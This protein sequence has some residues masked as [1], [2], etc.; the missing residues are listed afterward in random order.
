MVPV[1]TRG[2]RGCGGPG[3]PPRRDGRGAAW[4]S[5]ARRK[6]PSAARRARCRRSGSSGVEQAGELGRAERGDWRERA[7]GELELGA[8]EA[9]VEQDVMGDHHG[10]LQQPG[11]V[12]GD[13]GEGWCGG[14]HAVGDAVDLGG[15]DRPDR[16]QEGLVLLDHRPVG[17]QADDADLKGPVQ[18]PRLGASGLQVDHRPRGD[19]E[20]DPGRSGPALARRRLPVRQALGRRRARLAHPTGHTVAPLRTPGRHEIRSIRSDR[21]NQTPARPPCGRPRGHGLPTAR[22]CGPAVPGPPGMSHAGGTGRPS[23]FRRSRSRSLG[24]RT[25][26]GPGAPRVQGGPGGPALALPREVSA[27]RPAPPC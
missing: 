10:T 1:A 23:V 16:G 19:A 14:D 6:G 26:A 8:E 9:D 13:L 21:D 11:H 5:R 3:R 27:A 12:A 24:C 18:R 7:A 4:R 22:I 17:R 20:L 25:P 2:R 15:L